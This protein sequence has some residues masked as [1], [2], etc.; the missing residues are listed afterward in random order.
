MLEV[1]RMIQNI[2]ATVHDSQHLVTIDNKCNWYP[3]GNH[4]EQQQKMA[5][6]TT[7]LLSALHVKGRCSSGG[8]EAP[9]GKWNF[10]N[11]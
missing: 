4:C 9:P 1:D 10:G 6:A 3:I 8:G 2:L 7:P 5:G 11:F